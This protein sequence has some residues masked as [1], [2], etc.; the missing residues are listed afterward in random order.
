MEC[1]KHECK[2]SSRH[3]CDYCNHTPLNLFHDLVT[4]VPRPLPDYS[5]L[6][7]YHYLTISKTPVLIQNSLHPADDYQPRVQLRKE[8]EK[9]TLLRNHTINMRKFSE[10][11]IVDEKYVK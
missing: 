11:Y 8:F 1:R 9:G 6:P 5:S 2:R 3:L 4:P 7:N 10:K